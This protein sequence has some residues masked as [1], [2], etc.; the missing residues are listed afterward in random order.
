[1]SKLK[2]N[3]L[4]KQIVL[5]ALSQVKVKVN[6]GEADIVSE[7]RVSSII[8]RGGDVGFAIKID[9]SDVKQGEDLRAKCEEAVKSIESVEKVTAV[10][11]SSIDEPGNSNS[12]KL[13]QANKTKTNEDKK[14]SDS[15]GSNNKLRTIKGVKKIIVV[16]S[17]KGGVG[18]STVSVSLA[19]SLAKKGYKTAIADLDIY[20]PSIPKMLGLKGKPDIDDKNRMIPKEKNGIKSVSIGYIVDEENPVIWRSSMVLKA[21]D[22]MLLTSAWGDVDYL[23]IDTPPG[24]GDIQ[25]SLLKNYYIEGGVI[26][27]TPQEVALIDVKKAV[28]MFKKLQVPIIGVIENM[29]YFED[30]VSKNKTYIFGKGGARK[31]AENEGIN[32]L[33]EIPINQDI[34]KD[35]DEGSISENVDFMDEIVGNL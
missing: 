10:L 21:M 6:E 18:K 28:N 11:T 35:S 32:F 33:G 17:G 22:Q 24:T 26:V 4:N 16:A 30:P 7:D 31:L 20:G 14:S 9:S 12:E 15:I 8:I 1:M 34:N 3:E 13:S 5:D 29:S 27:S 23:V 2:N 19:A 25:L